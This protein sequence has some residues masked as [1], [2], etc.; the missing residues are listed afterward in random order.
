MITRSSHNP[1]RA[2]KALRVPGA[3][4]DTGVALGLALCAYMLGVTLIVTLV[5]FKFSIPE[6]SRIGWAVEPFDVGANILLFVPLGFFYRIGRAHVRSALHVLALGAMV[7]IAVESI[8]Y[9]EPARTPSP[10]DV[11]TN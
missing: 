7:S 9:F 3:A 11:M 8:Q 2:Q 10:V 4:A 6:A 1:R 5:P